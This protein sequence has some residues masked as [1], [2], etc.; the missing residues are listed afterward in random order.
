MKDASKNEMIHIRWSIK[1]K[2]MLVMTVVIVS[3]MLV[4]TYVQISSQQ[5]VLEG[6]LK[7]RITLMRENLVERGKGFIANLAQQ[8]ENDIAAFNF[9]GVSQAVT[10]SVE[11]NDDIKYAV[12]LDMEGTVYIHTL[13]PELAQS[14]L[15]TER[16]LRALHVSDISAV[17]DVEE[18]GG[19]IIKIVAPLQISTTPWGVLCLTYSLHHLEQ[20]IT[21]SEMEIKRQMTRIVYKSLLTFL[22][23]IL[24]AFVCVFILSTKFTGPLIN[25]THAARSLSKGQFLVP[26]HLQMSSKDEIGILAHSFIEMSQKLKSS[27]EQLEDYSRTLELKVD[28]RTKELHVSLQNVEK[29][30][31]KIMQSI[32]Y[33]K[34]IQY[35]LLPNKDEMRAWLPHHFII[36]M[37]RDVVG[38]DMFFMEFLQDRFILGVIDCTGHGVPGAFMTMI[39]SSILTRIIRDDRCTDPGEI[40][41]QLNMMVKNLLHQDHASTPLSD[42]GMDAAICCIKPRENALVFAGAKLPLLYT[43][44]G[45]VHIIK[46][47]R[48]SVG[49]RRSDEN[50]VFTNHQL[51]IERDMSYY[52][53]TDGYI[54][55]LGGS[56]YARFGTRRFRNLLREHSEKPFGQQE[57]ILLRTF[58]EFKGDNERQD[59]VT[60]VGFGFQHLFAERR[61]NAEKIE[62][63]DSSS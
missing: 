62:G 61:K 35:A 18:G 43:K 3:L 52:L 4:L 42:N 16:V 45:H 24:L 32:Q 7:K 8:V 17:E 60:V 9:S 46:G 6:E 27:Y 47:D 39:A 50:F 15:T 56:K 40:L 31:Q 51:T 37:P 55:Q 10:D 59:D 44:G 49:Y 30:N 53:L 22:G 63:T 5:A 1:W 13:H 41:Q 36:W 38:G 58:N 29:A 54:D 48:H 20:E 11:Q 26:I 57:K 34:L 19:A 21:R 25:L 28:E 33:A 2:L 14:S 23:F 12:L